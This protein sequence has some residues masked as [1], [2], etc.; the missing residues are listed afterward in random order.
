MK[1][2]ALFCD[3]VR[4]DETGTFIVIGVYPGVIYVDPDPSSKN[5]S[6]FVLITELEPGEHEARLM[7]TFHPDDGSDPQ[8]LGDDILSLQGGDDAALVLSP[9]GLQLQV[10]GPGFLTL[11]L[12]MDGSEPSEICSLK[13][14]VHIEEPR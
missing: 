8:V 7:M 6:N 1:I 12:G 9:S 14:L 10:K 11:R 4:R 3:D 5:I 13:V 2:Q